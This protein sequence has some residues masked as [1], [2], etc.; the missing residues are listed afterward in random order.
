MNTEKLKEISTSDYGSTYQGLADEYSDVDTFTLVRMPLSEGLFHDLRKQSTQDAD[1]RTLLT[2][3]RLIQLGLKGSIHSLIMLSAQLK[4][5]DDE[6]PMQS[7]FKT[8]YENH[9]A[10]SDLLKARKGTLIRSLFGI[11]NKDIDRVKKAQDNHELTGKQV[12]QECVDMNRI[13][14]LM[15]YYEGKLDMNLNY[16]NFIHDIT[17]LECGYKLYDLE[18]LVKTKRMKQ[19]ELL[20]QPIVQHF[21]ETRN[22]Y[23]KQLESHFRNHKSFYKDDVFE[24]VNSIK[25]DIVDY[26]I[27]QECLVLK[28]KGGV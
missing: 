19:D 28:S 7:L 25:Q 16:D 9:H 23:L 10:F 6:L 12:L 24:H 1:K 20:E 26:L 17:F 18:P 27:K 8:F 15:A 13:S 5:H 14:I 3:Q 2:P 11:M 21:F 4:Q 22:D